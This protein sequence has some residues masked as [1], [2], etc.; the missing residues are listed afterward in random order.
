MINF[1]DC[2]PN[3]ERRFWHEPAQDDWELALKIVSRD[4]FGTFK[5]TRDDRI[6]RGLLQHEGIEI[7][8]KPINGY[9]PLA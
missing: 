4:G 6:F 1:Q 3:Q 5:V 2:Q 7:I 8:I 9:I